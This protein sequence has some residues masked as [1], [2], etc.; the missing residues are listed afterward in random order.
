[1]SMRTLFLSCLALVAHLSIAT[2]A[3]AIYEVFGEG[4]KEKLKLEYEVTVKDHGTGRVTIYLT[5]ADEGRLTPL[6]SVDLYIPSKDKHS[7]GGYMAD[8]SLS[9][10]TNKVD[11]KLMVAGYGV[12]LKKDLAERAEIRLVTRTLDGKQALLTGYVHVIPIAKYMNHAPAEAPQP[13]PERVTNAPAAA[14]PATEH[15]PD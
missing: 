10:A 9:L 13:A 14:P 5:I 6:Q 11:G 2:H 1:M 12:H 3:S 4:S 7:N 8:L 15:K